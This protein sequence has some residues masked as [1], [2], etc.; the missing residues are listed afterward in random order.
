M[1][2]DDDLKTML[3]HALEAEPDAR[4]DERMLAAVALGHVAADAVGPF[5]EA[6]AAALHLALSTSPA[7]AL[8][9]LDAADPEWPWELMLESLIARLDDAVMHA[10]NLGLTLFVVWTAADELAAEERLEEEAARAVAYVQSVRDRLTTQRAN[11]NSLLEM[12]EQVSA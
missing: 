2:T 8:D 3:A 4:T 11:T 12:L 1:L 5:E 10:A 6:R 7:S 9:D